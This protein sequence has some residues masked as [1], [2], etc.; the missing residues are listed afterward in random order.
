MIQICGQR[1]VF[2]KPIIC[3]NIPHW[4][5]GGLPLE[6]ASAILW[7]LSEAIEFHSNKGGSQKNVNDGLFEK[8][9]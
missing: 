7:L 8:Y 2:Y 5:R 9:Y 4:K 1:S 3:A 6:I